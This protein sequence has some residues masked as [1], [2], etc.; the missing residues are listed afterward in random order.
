MPA[1]PVVLLA[2]QP[3]ETEALSALVPHGATVVTAATT[4]EAESRISQGVDAVVCTLEFDDSRMLDL[5]YEMRVLRP[6]IPVLCCR[7][8]GSRISDACVPAAATAAFSVGV[9]AFVDLANSMPG[10]GPEGAGLAAALMRL[11]A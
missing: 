4:H 11:L 1:A 5:V 2:C 9:S 6:D 3:S 8:A 10:V 7:V